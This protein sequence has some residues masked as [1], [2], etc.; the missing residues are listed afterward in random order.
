[1][2]TQSLIANVVNE[3][4]V[5]IKDFNCICVEVKMNDNDEINLNINRHL[6][7]NENHSSL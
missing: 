2:R 6:I 7:L 4:L 5:I 1:M 3:V